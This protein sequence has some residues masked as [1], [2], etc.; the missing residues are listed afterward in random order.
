MRTISDEELREFTAARER[1]A[2]AE[3]PVEPVENSTM[4]SIILLLSMLPVT[5]LAADGASWQW[6]GPRPYDQGA[7]CGENG[8]IPG[9]VVR[10]SGPIITIRDAG[11]RTLDG[12]CM[13]ANGYTFDKHITAPA[14]N[15]DFVRNY[16][17]RTG[18]HLETHD[19]ALAREQAE[20]AERLADQAARDAQAEA[21]RT[22]A[23]ELHRHNQAVLEAFLARCA[24][25]DVSER[26][27]PEGR[28]CAQLGAK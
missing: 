9:I 12:R 27:S 19:Q 23:D 26:K 13:K 15:P 3:G 7:A 22:R 18:V 21:E 20:A 4:R 28:E 8:V 2:Y 16:E 5:V 17:E 1:C 6:R 11:R 10:Q 24:A 25:L 14:L